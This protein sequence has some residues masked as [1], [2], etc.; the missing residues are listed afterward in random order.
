M[1][2]AICIAV[3][4]AVLVIAQELEEVPAV[5]SDD[6]I[7]ICKRVPICDDPGCS[8]A[9]NRDECLECVCEPTQPC[10]MPMCA[11]PPCKYGLSTNERGCIT[12]ECKESPCDGHKC[13]DGLSC[14]V[15]PETDEPECVGI[16]PPK[17]CP[18]YKC[19]ECHH[20][21][22]MVDGCQT[23]ECVTDPCEDHDCGADHLECRAKETECDALQ[24]PKVPNCGLKSLCHRRR[25]EHEH[26]R[27]DGE[28]HPEGAHPG[29][30]RPRPAEG[31]MGGLG[32]HMAGMRRVVRSITRL[33]NAPSMPECDGHGDFTPRQCHHLKKE[34]WCVDDRGLEVDGSRKQWAND[35]EKPGCVKNQTKSVHGKFQMNHDIE[36]VQ[37]H[38]DNLE[39]AT[40]KQMG[41]WLYIEKE[42][43][44]QVEINPA[45]N[46]VNIL[47]VEFVIVTDEN[48][49]VDLATAMYHLHTQVIH[50]ACHVEYQ[51]H[52]LT[53]KPETVQVQH[54]F[55]PQLPS[56][57]GLKYREDFYDEHKTALLAG[58]LGCVFLLLILMV[59]IK[60]VIA[61]KRSDFRHKRMQ[62]YKENL[63]FSNEIYGQLGGEKPRLEFVEDEEPEKQEEKKTEPTESNA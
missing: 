24:C 59:L 7:H 55:E 39:Q 41:Q 17:E 2:L 23:C 47:E 45:T 43:I 29:G 12:C 52:T 44:I 5:P 58:L 61:K 60:L 11:G 36:N 54:H 27:P 35:E 16:E 42:Y 49:E 33:M 38:I 40:Q 3:Q 51:G 10:A 8:L 26:R 56:N 57:G 19:V 37:D 48:G 18:M 31:M 22:K 20:G 32:M 46:E 15:H 6:I 63:A 30:E 21:Y 50:Q 14:K 25:D 1:K 4:L 62:T 13:E 53:P 9:R 28:P 34:C